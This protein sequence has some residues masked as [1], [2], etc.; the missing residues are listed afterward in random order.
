MNLP[1]FS[2]ARWGI[3]FALACAVLSAWLGHQAGATLDFITLRAV[4]VFVIVAALGFAAEAAMSVGIHPAARPPAE[5]QPNR[6]EGD[7]NA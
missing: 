5:R 3:Y 4:F 1:P 7:P 2:I 6:S